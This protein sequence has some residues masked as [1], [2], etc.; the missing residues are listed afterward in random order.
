MR[1]LESSRGGHRVWI[2]TKASFREIIFAPFT[3]LHFC[4]LVGKCEAWRCDNHLKS[5]GLIPASSGRQDDNANDTKSLRLGDEGP[6]WFCS[7][8]PGS[9]KHC[10]LHRRCGQMPSL[11]SQLYTSLSCLSRMGWSVPILTYLGVRQ[12]NSYQWKP[13]NLTFLDT[14]VSHFSNFQQCYISPFYGSNVCFES[15]YIA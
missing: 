10:V 8:V 11:G 12:I 1:C 5:W 4:C 7:G 15:L 14:S 2:K 6:Y 13:P 9:P 3:F